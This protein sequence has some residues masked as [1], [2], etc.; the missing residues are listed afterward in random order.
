MNSGLRRNA[1]I[2]NNSISCFLV[3]HERVYSTEVTN[4]VRGIGQSITAK[5]IERETKY[6]IR[7]ARRN[8]LTDAIR[9]QPYLTQRW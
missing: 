5:I 8:S 7:M 9:R 3:K 1:K 4:P 6:E 2:S